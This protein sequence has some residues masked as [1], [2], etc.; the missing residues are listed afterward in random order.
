[1]PLSGAEAACVTSGSNVTCT[2]TTLN[3]NGN[4]GFG[5]GTQNGLTINVQSGASVSGSVN[6]LHLGTDNTV[7][8]AGTISGGFDGIRADSANITNS[9]TIS[10]GALGF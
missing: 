2:D 1:M 9:G 5:D 3:G 8:N 6:G 10:G 7:I 4:N